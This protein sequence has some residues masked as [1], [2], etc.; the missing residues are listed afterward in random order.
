MRGRG[1]TQVDRAHPVL[2]VALHPQ[3]ANHK[4]GDDGDQQ[5]Q[6]QVERRYLPAEE[7]QQQRER[8]LVDHRRGDEEGECH[9][10]GNPGGEEADEERNRR[11]GT[12]RGDDAEQR[13]QGIADSEPAARQE[14]A[15]ARRGE[16]RLHHPHDEDDPDQQEQHLGRVIE[17]EVHG[18]AEASGA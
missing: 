17:E 10:Q 3:P 11:T 15:G 16:E 13:C 5:P 4:T 8:H 7:S 2:Q 12:E 14:R 18:L 1:L 6:P 9:P